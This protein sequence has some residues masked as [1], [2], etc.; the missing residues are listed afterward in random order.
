MQSILGSATSA[1][2]HADPFPHVFVPEA[3]GAAYYDQLNAAFPSLDQVARGKPIRNNASY[4]LSGQECLETDEFAPIWREF[5]RYHLGPG[6]FRDALKLLANHFR[7]THPNIDRIIGKPIEEA[8]VG[9]RRGGATE[10]IRLDCQFGINSPVI[11]QSRVR[12]VHLDNQRKL[13]NA[14][15]YM[16]LPED[17]SSGGNLALFEFHQPPRQWGVDGDSRACDHATA[18]EVGQIPYRPN[19]LVLFVNSPRSFHGVTPRTV[20]P[21]VRRYI[22]FLAE[23]REPLFPFP[24]EPSLTLSRSFEPHPL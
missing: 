16:R 1:N 17:D 4:L 14:L 2:V 6:F 24:P 23:V 19:F 12:G 18:R 13:F 22:N 8:T 11:E 21:H 20:T 10:D 9:M 15:L 7:K 5:M 3:L